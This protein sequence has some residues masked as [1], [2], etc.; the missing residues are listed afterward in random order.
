MGLTHSLSASAKQKHSQDGSGHGLSWGLSAMQGYRPTMEDDHTVSQ[1]IPVMG[2]TSFFAVYDGHAGATLSYLASTGV[3]PSI[4][5]SW[6]NTGSDMS[7]EKIAT[8][9]YNGIIDFDINARISNPNLKSL[10]DHSGST[11]ISTFVTPT[12]IIFANVGDSRAVLVRNNVAVF[13]T[14]DHKPQS[15]IETNRVLAAG[16]YIMMGRV[17]GNLAVS[18]AL[19]DYVYKDRPDLP[20]HEQKMSAA[21]DL[22]VVTRDPDDQVL[23]IGC[24]GIWDV[25][26]NEQATAFVLKAVRNGSSPVEIAEKLIDVCLRRGSTD[27][28]SVIIV[29]FD[30]GTTKPRQGRWASTRKRS[31]ALS[32][33]SISSAGSDVSE[34]ARV[35]PM[36]LDHTRGRGS[37]SKVAKMIAEEKNTTADSP[38]TEEDLPDADTIPMNQDQTRGRGS[39]LV[40]G[41]ELDRIRN[42]ISNLKLEKQ[43]SNGDEGMLDGERTPT[44]SPEHHHQ[45]P[46]E[47]R[48]TPEP[49]EK[50]KKKSV[51]IVSSV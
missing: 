21:A 18:R 11:L 38:L 3:L 40:V 34:G 7:G 1:A 19:G 15:P 9:M 4:L 31:S 39:V 50:S 6:E 20:P 22:T 24:D 23:I 47:G 5:A 25:M 13:G 49:E 12:E 28:M 51:G 29:L 27:N 45:P 33:T 16:G 17:C 46:D 44:A 26:T 41:E 36:S 2:D 43:K 35:L 8:A 37:T 48:E 14:E 30:E 10:R 42:Q 32:V